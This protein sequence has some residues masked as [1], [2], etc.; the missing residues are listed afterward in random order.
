[1]TTRV[2]PTL[3]VA[4]YREQARLL[5]V[6]AAEAAW[7]LVVSPAPIEAHRRFRSLTAAESEELFDRLLRAAGRFGW[8][9]RNV[10]LVR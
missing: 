7:S 6:E 9:D 8:M 3:T 4:Q 5:Q 10:R 1:M 2:R